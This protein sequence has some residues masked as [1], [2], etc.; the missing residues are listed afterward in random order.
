MSCGW[1]AQLDQYADGELRQ[2]ELQKLESHL[3][4][5]SSCAAEALGRMQLKRSVHVAA[6]EAFAPSTELKARLQ[7]VLTPQKT[8]SQRWLPRLAF[9]AAV[10]AVALA[11]ALLLTRNRSQQDLLAEAID[12]HVSTLAS[13][14]PVDVVSTDRHTVKP[15]FQGKLPFTF[16]LPELA[17]SN[18]RLLGGRMAYI[19]QNPAAQLVFGVNKHQISVFIFKDL[20]H[21]QAAA[22]SSVTEQRLNFSLE[23]WTQ[24]GLRYIAVS[25][26][27]M[28]D[29]Q[30]LT[31]LFRSAH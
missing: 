20:G 8:T 10:I 3:R 1:R 5:C 6:A 7:N 31:S 28:A 30:A 23:S 4:S 14:N 22:E 24:N 16:N 11:A 2:S 9:S 15:W 18:F 26:A 29:V 25:D 12:L 21:R 27:G 17:N 13:A 19:G